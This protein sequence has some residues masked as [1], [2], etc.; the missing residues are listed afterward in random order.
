MAENKDKILSWPRQRFVWDTFIESGS[1]IDWEKF[2]RPEY[3]RL[4]DQHGPW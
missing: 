1:M 2:W 4:Y 3:E